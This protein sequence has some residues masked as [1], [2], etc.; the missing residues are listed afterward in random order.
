MVGFL[1]MASD[2]RVHAQGGPRG[3]NL[4]HFQNV[5]LCFSFHIKMVSHQTASILE[6]K[7]L[8]CGRISYLDNL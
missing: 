4:L 3:H 6:A 2:P 1:S 7:L 8:F 5:F